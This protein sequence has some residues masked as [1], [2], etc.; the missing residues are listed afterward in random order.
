MEIAITVPTFLSSCLCVELEMLNVGAVIVCYFCFVFCLGCVCFCFPFSGGGSAYVKILNNWHFDGNQI[1]LTHL[2][3]NFCDFQCFL[4]WAPACCP[5]C[6]IIMIKDN[7]NS[8]FTELFPA[9]CIFVMCISVGF[10]I[11]LKCCIHFELKK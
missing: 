1:S 4:H 2:S 8:C 7:F 9:L 3:L 11:C 6:I 5:I 10:F